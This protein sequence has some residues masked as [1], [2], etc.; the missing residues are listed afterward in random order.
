MSLCHDD[1]SHGTGFFHINCHL[2]ANVI[3]VVCYYGQQVHISFRCDYTA[4]E[5][6]WIAGIS[7]KLPCL[8]RMILKQLP[9]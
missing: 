6:I 3:K 8:I 4:L 1:T 2:N 9:R 5:A 7:Q